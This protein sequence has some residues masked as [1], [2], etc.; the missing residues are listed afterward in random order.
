M[1]NE[2]VESVVVGSATDKRWGFVVSLTFQSACLLTLILIPLI[3][4]QALP[5]AMMSTFLIAPAALAPTPP[6]A[7]EAAIGSAERS[8]RLIGRGVIAEPHRFPPHAEI[9]AEAPPPESDAGFGVAGGDGMVDLLQ[10]LAD[11]SRQFPSL[12][13]AP[14]P[15]PERAQPQRVQIGGT[16]QAAQ[17]ISGVQPIYPVLAQQTRTQGAVVLHAIIDKDGH[18]SAL[19]VI[20]GHPLL[21]KA[22]IDAVAQWRYQPTLLNGQA[23]EVETTITVTFVLDG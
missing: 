16:I 7:P 2:L 17:L 8:S 20:S 13:A 14:T 21:V 18:V 6:A 12:P 9:F 11:D 1:F 15:A 5:K 4:T 19:Q 22:A 10:G 23:V 3:Y